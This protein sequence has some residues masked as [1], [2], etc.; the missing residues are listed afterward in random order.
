VKTYGQ[1]CALA[2]ALDHVGD[3]WT[4]LIV[5]EL[6]IGPRRYSQIRAAL[7]GIATNLLADRLRTLESDEVVSRTPEGTY[8]LT[9]FG[10]GLEDAVQ[11]LVRWGGHWMGERDPRDTFQPDWLVV[12]L[13][14]LLPRATGARVE[15]RVDGGAISFDGDEIRAG[16][17]EDPHAIVYGNPETILGVATGA[18]PLS[19]LSISGSPS[20]VEAVMLPGSNRQDPVSPG[21]LE[22]R[23][24]SIDRP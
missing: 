15:L 3:R 7:P 18:V 22:Q 24:I 2:K 9:G 16:G 6:L 13:R 21:P 1:Y 4:L 8:E 10:R 19:E 12:A 11:G 23:M 17:I 20:A 5:R 14:A